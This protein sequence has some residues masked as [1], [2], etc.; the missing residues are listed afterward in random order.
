MLDPQGAYKENNQREKHPPPPP[1]KKKNTTQ[2][3]N[4]HNLHNTTCMSN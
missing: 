3:Q 2:T 4:Q 1:P